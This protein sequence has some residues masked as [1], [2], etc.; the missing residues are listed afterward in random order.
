[1]NNMAL[2]DG[3]IRPAPVLNAASDCGHKPSTY[4]TVGYLSS[5]AFYFLFLITLISCAGRCCFGK[6]HFG[7]VDSLFCAP[8][9]SSVSA[10]SLSGRSGL[11]NHKKDIAHVV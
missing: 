1:M 10:A 4:E 2:G 6:T 3:V 7:L 5:M 8:E 11:G 9:T